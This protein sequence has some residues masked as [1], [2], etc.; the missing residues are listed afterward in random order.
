MVD[1]VWVSLASATLEVVVALEDDLTLR[2]QAF[3][4]DCV[5]RDSRGEALPRECFPKQINIDP[6]L[7]YPDVFDGV[8]HLFR[9]DYWFVSEHCAAVL[10]SHDLG[11]G[12]LYYVEFLQ[13]DRKTKVVGQYYALNIGNTKRTFVPELSSNA[14]Q[15]PY[16]A[17][18]YQLWPIA[19]DGDIAVTKDALAGHDIWIEPTLSGSFFVSDKL[20]NAL[21]SAGCDKP[22]QLRRCRV[23]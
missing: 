13:M 3:S 1:M 18:L 8:R 16:S 2:D 5:R 9:G 19:G 23:V 12:A 17:T 4:M 22:F 21:R 10:R 14:P 20:A 6:N 11:G 7:D 15:N